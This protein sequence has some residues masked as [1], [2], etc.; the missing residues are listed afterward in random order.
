MEISSPTPSQDDPAKAI[1][2]KSK[3]LRPASVQK[4][5]QTELK[6]K[7]PKP[8]LESKRA[9]R[10]TKYRRKAANAKERDRMKHLNDAFDRLRS[11]MP[12]VKTLAQDDKDTKVT[13]LRAA[14]TYIGC[15]QQLM[16]DL[17]EGK[18]DPQEYKMNQEE[19]NSN[20]KNQTRTARISIKNKEFKQKIKLKGKISKSLFSSEGKMNI[21]RSVENV[22]HR[23]DFSCTSLNLPNKQSLETLRRPRPD[24]VGPTLQPRY[25]PQQTDNTHCP[26]LL[27]LEPLPLSQL[28]PCKISKQIWDQGDLKTV[29]PRDS[30]SGD[31]FRLHDTQEMDRRN[32]EMCEE[33]NHLIVSMLNQ[34]LPYNGFLSE[35]QLGDP[36]SMKIVRRNIIQSDKKSDS[37]DGDNPESPGTIINSDEPSDTD[38]NDDSREL[39]SP[40]KLI[41][42][43]DQ[44]F[45]RS[46]SYELEELARS[47]G[48]DQYIFLDHLVS[49][50]NGDNLVILD[51]IHSII[52]EN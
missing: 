7:L 42:T 22:S 13:T 31:M 14:I 16:E 11:V 29:M 2:T 8:K 30:V 33:K 35:E 41:P 17:D 34:E 25:K 5:I 18:V 21:K 28:Y 46:F 40:T 50:V 12:D 37:I 20:S 3:S 6:L 45:K 19:S 47:C 23:T 48:G 38:T 15:L 44:L 24:L 39:P 43:I 4:R 32:T 51:D 49:N 9:S 26:N 10:M 27:T 36:Q 1:P 52:K